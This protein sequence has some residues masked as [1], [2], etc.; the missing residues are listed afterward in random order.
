MYSVAK[1]VMDFRRQNIVCV[2]HIYK[3]VTVKKQ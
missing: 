1:V 2:F 3:K